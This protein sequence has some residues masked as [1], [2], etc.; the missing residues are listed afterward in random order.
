ML[1]GIQIYSFQMINIF[2]AA[3]FVIDQP[4]V[5]T[6]YLAVKN[7]CLYSINEKVQMR[8]CVCLP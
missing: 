7:S 5:A 2:R 8:I 1:A 6:Y 4:F 3:D